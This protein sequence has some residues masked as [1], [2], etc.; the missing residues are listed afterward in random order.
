MHFEPLYHDRLYIVAG[1]GSAW[2]RKRKVVLSDLLQEPWL[3]PPSQGATLLAGFGAK[4]LASPKVTVRAYSTHQCTYLI[5][6]NRFV[7]ALSGSMLRFSLNREAIKV[8]PVDFPAQS[9]TVGIMRLKSRNLAPTAQ[10]FME[11][12]RKVAVRFAARR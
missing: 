8:L 6:T 12:I 2:A 11:H 4:G 1:R 9:W 3:L 5:A 7:S 10:V